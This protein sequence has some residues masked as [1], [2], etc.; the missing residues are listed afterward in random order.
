MKT[1]DLDGKIQDWKIAGKVFTH[2]QNV[3]KSG[4]HLKCRELLAELYPTIQV[5]EEVPINPKRGI[6]LYLDFYLKLLNVAIEVHGEQHYKFTPHFHQTQAGFI[7]YKQNERLK[8]DWCTRN[9]ITLIELPFNEEI[10]E[11]KQ[12]ICS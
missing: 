2:G 5:L 8:K 4:L 11:W 12:R 3:S 6:T 9:G 7:K 1:I 10:N